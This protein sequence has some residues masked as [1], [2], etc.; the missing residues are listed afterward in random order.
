[1]HPLPFPILASVEDALG[2]IRKIRRKF[3]VGKSRD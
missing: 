1:M 2:R 3:K